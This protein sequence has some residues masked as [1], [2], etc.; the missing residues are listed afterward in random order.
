MN[1]IEIKKYSGEGFRAVM[2]FEGWKI[3]IF[4]SAPCWQED[5]ST[6]VQKHNKSDEAFVL[7]KG[8]C[9]LYISTEETPTRLTAFPM[10][11]EL[12]YNIRKGVWHTHV[13]EDDTTVVVVENSDTVPENSPKLPLPHPL[14]EALTGI[15]NP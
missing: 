11:P 2:E 13:L 5:Q 7:L 6:Y 1:G 4:N 15:P 10:E 8:H 9:T 14:C 12:V 3:G